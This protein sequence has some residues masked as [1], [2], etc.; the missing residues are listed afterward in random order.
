MGKSEF[1]IPN[2]LPGEK[3]QPQILVDAV[4]IFERLLRAEMMMTKVDRERY[5][6][7]AEKQIL[8]VIGDFYIAYDFED[9][10]ETYLKRMWADIS[11]FLVTMSII[12]KV[13]AIHVM[14]NP[15]YD[16]STPDQMKRELME[17]IA[18]LDEG[19]ARWK[20]SVIKARKLR[21]GNETKGN[22]GMTGI[23]CDE[24]AVSEIIKEVR[25]LR[26]A[27]T[28]AEVKSKE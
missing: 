20:K 8:N 6:H 21:A 12:A 9:D 23:L 17:H 26:E 18:K 25:L 24:P 28:G 11:A 16:R 19:A 27:L 14:P 7:L 22:K 2:L 4:E 13:N 5:C 10:R 15:K 1:Y 3:E